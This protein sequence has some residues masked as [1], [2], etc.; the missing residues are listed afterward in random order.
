MLVYD[1][2]V[3][4]K[5][6]P[7]SESIPGKTMVKNGAGGYV[8]AVS[9]WEGLERFLILGAEGGSYYVR[10][11]ELVVQNAKVVERCIKEDGVRVVNKVVEI[12][13]A[14]RAPKNSSALFVLAMCSSPIFADDKTR[15]E[16]LAKL[17]SVARTGTHL[18]EFIRY[19]KAVGRGWGRSMK[20][21]VQSWYQEKTPDKLAFQLVK[22]R[23]RGGWS[24]RDVLRLCKPVPVDVYHDNLYAW[25]TGGKTD[26]VDIPKI[27]DGFERCRRVRWEHALATK[28][29]VS[30]INT[31]GL[32]HEAIPTEFKDQRD[33][34]DALLVNMP[35]MATVRNLAN[36]TRIGLLTPMSQAEKIVI[37]RLENT[38]ILLKSRIHPL[39][40]LAALT[41][42]SRGYSMKQGDRTWTP[43]P[44]IVDV[45]DSAFYTTFKNVDVTGKRW[46]LA[47]DVS[48]S[49]TF[50]N[51]AGVGGIT[52]REGTAAM[53][54]ITASVEKQYT[55]VGFTRDIS[56]LNISPRMR[57]DDAI[58]SI[59]NLPFGGT[60]CAQPMLWAMK[61]NIQ[62]DV[63]VI[64]TDNE[65]WAGNIHPI[66]ALRD[67]QQK[68]GI[69]A[70]L[71]VVGMT[72]D[73][74]S[75]ADPNSPLMMDVVG[76]DTSVPQVMS[77]FVS[78]K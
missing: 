26:F 61:N 42:Y 58:E 66:L 52:P 5:E 10:E 50:D 51:L 6:T 24:H 53:A 73:G 76:F 14:G 12:S 23:N 43:N 38:D 64:Y 19:S 3:N 31:Y 32:P 21:A 65:T 37:D 2:Y 13:L 30:I 67:Y 62:A 63:F 20:R 18:F 9:D 68:M 7:Q 41:T 11:K 17:T 44:H 55:I 27:V 48:G 28:A 25:V 34:W 15:K 74:F 1:K 69:A 49:M 36:M 45:L 33:V 54:L 60:D 16:A 35:I 47:L 56:T 40:I 29:I 71:I 77:E 78:D 70:K 57:L 22:Y 4:V 75:I 59:S 46:V 72:S 8:F 39:Q